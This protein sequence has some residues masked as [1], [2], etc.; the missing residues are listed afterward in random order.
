MSTC[1]ALNP[2][3]PNPE[4]WPACSD[5]LL[6]YQSDVT[7][8]TELEQSLAKLTELQ[9]NTLCEVRLCTPRGLQCCQL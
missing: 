3:P 6:I 2:E 1:E 5:V 7:V 4:P 9:L 8:R